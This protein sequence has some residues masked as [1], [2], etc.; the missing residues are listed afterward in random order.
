[1]VEVS[2]VEHMAALSQYGLALDFVLIILQSNS[3]EK[4]MAAKR[5]E[6]LISGM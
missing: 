6:V 2:P 1:M 3:L 5:S 4:P